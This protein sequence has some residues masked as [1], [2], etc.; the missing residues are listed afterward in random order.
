MHPS[1][2]ANGRN[3]EHERK[4]SGSPCFLLLPSLFPLSRSLPFISQSCS[5]FSHLTSHN[6]SFP[7]VLPSSSGEITKPR[8]NPMSWLAGNSK[9]NKPKSLFKNC[10]NKR[11]FWVF[12]SEILRDWIN[13]LFMGKS[14][15][16]GQMEHNYSGCAWGFSY[17]I[18][19]LIFQ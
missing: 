17:W 2:S 8:T 13:K 3:P 14:I 19:T 4:P 7:L 10:V 9:A 5:L 1:R 12:V 16:L 18:S 11:I 6:G 15:S